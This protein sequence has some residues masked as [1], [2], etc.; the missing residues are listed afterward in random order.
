MVSGRELLR[1][2]I[3]T[4]WSID[5]SEVIDAVYHFENGTL[6]LKAEHFD[7]H[8][9]PPGE[10]EKYTPLLAECF[11]QGGWFYG[12]FDGTQ[13]IGVAVLE[14]RFIGSHKDQLQL[15]FLEVSQAFRGQ[16]HGRRLF[17]LAKTVA[18]E[19][20]ARRLYISATPSEH[21]IHFYFSLG[22][23]VTS[24]PDPELLALEPED[25]HLECSL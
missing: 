21:T 9:W 22:C 8:T 24:E 4:V 16:G 15:K 14:N 18:R 6:V 19:K 25:I 3:E 7:L 1:E 5:R 17:E 23:V 20:G 10:P 13:L 2:E 12:L 11:E